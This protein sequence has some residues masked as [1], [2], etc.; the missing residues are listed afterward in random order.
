MAP[1]RL[2]GAETASSPGAV[3]VCANC[4]PIGIAP[5]LALGLLPK[6]SIRERLQY[7]E[8]A[9]R[10]ESKRAWSVFLELTQQIPSGLPHPDGTA[11]IRQARI[12]FH[13][14]QEAYLR[15]QR[16]LVDYLVYGVI[17]DDL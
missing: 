6:P 13:A 14:A 2:C 11:R 12:E 1:C 16:R 7:E 17:P 15:A 3:P 8:G 10:D 9:A 4:A 5:G